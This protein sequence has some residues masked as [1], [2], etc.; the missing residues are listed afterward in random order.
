MPFSSFSIDWSD[1]TGECSTKDPTGEQHF[2]CTPSHP[3]VCPTAA[4]LK[5]ITSLEVWAE[6][7]SGNF[8]LEIDW[9]GATAGAPSPPSPSPTPSGKFVDLV[10]I[11]TSKWRLTNDPVMG[12]LSHSTISVDKENAEVNFL[13][14][15]KIVPKLKAPGFCDA[16]TSAGLLGKFPSAAGYDGIQLVLKAAGPLRTFKQSWG[17]HGTGEFGSFKAGFNL[18]D[19]TDW[20]TVFIPW[21]EYTNKWSDFTGG[22]T[23]HGA[24][25]CSEAHPE[26]CP[27]A[28][29]KAAIG[30]IG[31]WGEGTAGKFDLTIKSIRAAMAPSEH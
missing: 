3:E 17:A 18:T 7:T 2:C 1:Y 21:K 5:K 23:D 8:S 28:K 11:A 13:G 31:I 24:I 12:G 14:E 9:I 16:E 15:V 29:A 19:S 20:Q 4:L 25:C 10:D 6:G 26:V 30:T 22:C 27:T